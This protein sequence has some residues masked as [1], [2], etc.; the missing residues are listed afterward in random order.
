MSVNLALAC[1]GAQVGLMD[2]DIYGPSIPTLMGISEKPTA[3]A[4]GRMLPVTPYD[5]KVI[6]MGFFL[7]KRRPSSGGVRCWIR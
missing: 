4:Q 2:A 1:S 6:S 7:P 3:A 5:V